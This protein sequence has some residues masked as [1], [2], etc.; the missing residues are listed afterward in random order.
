M[1]G[2]TFQVEESWPLPGGIF[3]FLFYVRMLFREQTQSVA[4]MFDNSSTKQ[5]RKCHFHCWQLI[6]AAS[7][8][9]LTQ[10]CLRGGLEQ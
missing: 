6:E 9:H 7:K 1:P 10:W 3:T 2:G 8:Q 4:L 5:G